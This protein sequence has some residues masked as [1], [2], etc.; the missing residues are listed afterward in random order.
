[1][2]LL[3]VF[4]RPLLSLLLLCNPLPLGL[5]LGFGLCFS[6]GFLSCTLCTTGFR[7]LLQSKEGLLLLLMPSLHLT[8]LL[9]KHLGVVL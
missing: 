3:E 8:T 4:P 6:P 1:M 7:C 2:E 9:L 5:F